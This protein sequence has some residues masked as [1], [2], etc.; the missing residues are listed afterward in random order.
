MVKQRFITSAM[1]FTSSKWV[2]SCF[3]FR[4]L[5]SA[6]THFAQVSSALLKYIADLLSDIVRVLSFCG[7]VLGINLGGPVTGVDPTLPSPKSYKSE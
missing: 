2:F 1:V 4:E 7:V 6:Q 5:F 3:S